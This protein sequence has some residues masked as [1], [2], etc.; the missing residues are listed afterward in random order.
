MIDEQ[1]YLQDILQFG[2]D[3]ARIRQRINEIMSQAPD[4]DRARVEEMV[5][6]NTAL[7]ERADAV[8]NLQQ[9]YNQ[10]ASGIAGEM[11]GAF[12]SIIDGTKS[13]DEAFAD[14][15][16][17]IADKF[18]DMAMKI[19]TDAITQQLMSLFSGLFGGFGGGGGFNFG[20]LFW[21]QCWSWKQVSVSRL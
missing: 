3:E 19:L 9:Q 5:R 20:S 14:M 12:R 11:T 18:L 15:L 2:E 8:A 7:Q 16:K 10:L 21:H 17:G 4:L 13:V 6:G 1:T